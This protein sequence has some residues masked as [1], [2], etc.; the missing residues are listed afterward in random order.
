MGRP[1]RNEKSTGPGR[2]SP[3]TRT[4]ARPGERVARDKLTARAVPLA[5]EDVP[6]ATDSAPLRMVGGRALGV[7]WRLLLLGVVVAVISVTLAQSL[8]V[9]FAQRQE[10]AQYRAEIQGTL[11]HISELEDQLERWND[12]DFV[13]A[14]ARTRLGWVMPG[15]TGYRV[16]GAD[17]QPL[18]GDSDVLAAA[19]D[20]PTGEWWERVWG[21]V[22]AA[23][24]PLPE[25]TPSATPIPD[26]TDEP[27]ATPTPSE[28]P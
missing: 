4:A 13:R 11:D 16:I 7:T 17:G 23:D 10:I 15:E 6:S 5:A 19:G 20:V 14:E 26:L 12:P 2:G 9:Y 3:H 18:G 27:L 22:V 1:G 28:T 24:E 21:S 8:R 25:A